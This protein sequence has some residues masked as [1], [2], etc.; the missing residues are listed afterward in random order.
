MVLISR[1]QKEKKEV[2]GIVSQVGWWCMPLTL[3]FR[4]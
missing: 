3:A 4:R 1:R 2:V